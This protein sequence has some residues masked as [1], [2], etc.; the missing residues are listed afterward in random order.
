MGD[1]V[2]FLKKYF[3]VIISLSLVIV[4]LGFF[5]K[6]TSCSLDGENICFDR[7]NQTFKIEA[8][9]KISVQVETEAM[10]SYIVDMW[11]KTHPEF[12][13]ALT[14][15]VKPSLTLTQLA[16]NF[17]TDLILT[18]INN[19]AFVLNEV[20]DL[21][22]KTDRTIMSRIPLS[23]SGA[24]N[25]K[26]TFFVPNS[27]KG[28]TFVYN[29]TLAEEIGLDLEDSDKNGLPD[30]FETFE[31][32]FELEET[33]LKELDILFPLSFQDQYSFY[34]FLTSSRWHLNF[35]NVG[36]DPGF[37]HPE[38]LKGL[39]LIE[40]FSDVK[41]DNTVEDKSAD[42]LPWRY[43]TAI[44]NRE[45]VFSLMSDW[46]NFEYYQDKLS[47]E[48]VIAPLPTFNG[49][50]LYAKGS[51]DG[52]MISK[53][54][55]Y[56][57]ATT[58]ALRLLRSLETA[59]IY[60]IVNDKVF[61]YHRNYLDE[62]AFEND[63]KDKIRALNFIDPDPVMVLESNNA[64]LARDLLYEVDIMP[65]LMDLFDKKIDKIEA[66]AEIMKLADAWLKEHGGG[67]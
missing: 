43:D 49:N 44:Y 17:E 3:P 42:A 52:Y 23:L 2:K 34:P 54:T 5:V 21:G 61:A 53:E 10:A 56:P 47:D 66:Q 48:L 1:L 15:V 27:V 22:A 13:G 38:F 37:K 41:L 46:M 14:A 26:G 51:V 19:A 32:I 65:V 28:W 64:K 55:H 36:E 20:V 30:S 31:N 35:T 59:P 9:A 4:G 11:D 58:E 16:D 60:G 40:K 67:E 50:H 33:I 8:D 45:S 7:T 25:E 63:L 24:L 29:K 6:L 18:S 57:S 62:I 39:E 12:K